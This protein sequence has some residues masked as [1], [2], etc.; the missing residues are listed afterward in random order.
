M[1]SF[2]SMSSKMTATGI[3]TV[4]EH[5]NNYAEL[6]AYA[7]GLDMLFEML[8]EM[9]REYFIDTAESFGILNRERFTGAV[10]DDLSIEKR[11]EMLKI[12]ELTN[13]KTCSP[14]SFEKILSG[15][16]LT[17][18]SITE[19]PSTRMVLIKINDNLS[20]SDRVWVEYM[21]SNDF[22]V[23]LNVQVVF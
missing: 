15:Y 9:K 13:E 7:A 6:K 16:G 3:Y 22:P 20:E 12:R 2:N 8:D 18:F 19:H 21:I 11:R 17:N 4:T 23:H 1:D 5:S 14:A 10:R